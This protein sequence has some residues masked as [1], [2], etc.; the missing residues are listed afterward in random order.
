MADIATQ[1]QL[2]ED[3]VLHWLRRDAAGFLYVDQQK[4]TFAPEF[5]NQTKRP[6]FLV[7]IPTVGF[8]GL[9]VKCKNPVRSHFYLDLDEVERCT[10]FEFQFNM[11]VWYVF[12]TPHDMGTAYIAPHAKMALLPVDEANGKP[13]VKIDKRQNLLKVDAHTTALT[14]AIYKAATQAT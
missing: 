10:N 14:D 9:E 8:F 1:G 4:S 2:A 6:D 5:R 11:A 13:A 7:T 12:F 3:Y